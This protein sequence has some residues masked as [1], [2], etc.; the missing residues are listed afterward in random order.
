MQPAEE[1][2]RREAS[3]PL[4]PAREGR[5]LVQRSV[6][7]HIVV[8]AGIGLQNPAQVC[9]AQGDHVVDAL[10]S[11]R[12]GAVM[13]DYEAK[14]VSDPRVSSIRSLGYRMYGATCSS[15]G[16]VFFFPKMLFQLFL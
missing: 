8:I 13:A 4:N 16:F 7:S 12:S 1:R 15:Y 3:D 6:R 11:N 2:M 14:S 5:V 10:A 9:L